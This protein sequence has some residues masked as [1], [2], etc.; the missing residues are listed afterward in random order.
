MIDWGRVDQLRDEIGAEDFREVVDMFLE[1]VDEI[2]ER[3]SASP[4]PSHFEEDLHFLKGSAL[5]LGFQKFSALCAAGEQISAAGD[6]D[7]VEIGPVIA[8]Y[9]DSKAQFLPQLETGQAA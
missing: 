8:C 5:N 7:S 4:D 2:I 1:E 9:H 6:A 3:L